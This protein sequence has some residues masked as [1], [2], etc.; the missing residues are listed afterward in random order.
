MVNV[1]RKI[2]QR[3]GR[4]REGSDFSLA[5]PNLLTLGLGILNFSSSLVL[6]FLLWK[7]KE[8]RCYSVVCNSI[9]LN[10]VFCKRIS[11]KFRSFG[12]RNLFES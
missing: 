3:R 4:G 12:G 2:L 1:K 11:H 6:L 5:F 10:Q 7:N 8:V 9:H